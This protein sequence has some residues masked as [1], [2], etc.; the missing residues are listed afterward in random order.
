[1]IVC[2]KSV[3]RLQNKII[4]SMWNKFSVCLF[5]SAEITEAISLAL[6]SVLRAL[7]NFSGFTGAFSKPNGQN[8]TRPYHVFTFI[9][10]F[11]ISSFFFF[12][13]LFILFFFFYLNVATQAPPSVVG[14]AN[15]DLSN[16]HTT[17]G[18]RK[19]YYDKG[20]VVSYPL[21]R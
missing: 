14:I 8:L 2:G 20:K 13:S 19:F 11:L 5:C 18:G 10:L 7:E 6:H 1:M 9:Y 4:T 3:T 12:S 17:S 21:C 16:K 15:W